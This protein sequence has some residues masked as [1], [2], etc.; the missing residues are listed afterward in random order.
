MP[1]PH[2][3]WKSAGSPHFPNQA[4]PRTQQLDFP[5]LLR[6]HFGH[7]FGLDPVVKAI[8][9]IRVKVV[10]ESTLLVETQ[11]TCIISE[12]GKID[13]TKPMQLVK[14]E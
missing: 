2:V 11:A 10:T 7:T 6:A 4:P 13:G 3:N 12:H 1:S 14:G 9:A 8:R 5:A